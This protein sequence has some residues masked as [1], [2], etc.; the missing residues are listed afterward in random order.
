MAVR[1]KAA[2][3]ANLDCGIWQSVLQGG[4]VGT[5]Q[6]RF[7]SHDHRCIANGNPGLLNLSLALVLACEDKT[8]PSPEFP[9]SYIC[10]CS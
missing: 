6:S 2:G 8:A 3:G 9:A 4:G 7:Y 10:A 5:I 1:F